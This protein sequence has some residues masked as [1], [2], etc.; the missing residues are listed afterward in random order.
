MIKKNIID[1]A[2]TLGTIVPESNVG[3][4][5]K[6]LVTSYDVDPDGFETIKALDE[7]FDDLRECEEEDM[8]DGYSISSHDYSMLLLHLIVNDGR[9]FSSFHDDDEDDDSEEKSAIHLPSG[10]T[11]ARPHPL[12]KNVEKPRLFFD[13]QRF[14]T[15]LTCWS[16]NGVEWAFERSSKLIEESEP[17]AV[18]LHGDPVRFAEKAQYLSELVTKR[19]GGIRVLAATYGDSYGPNPKRVWAKCAKALEKFVDTLMSNC[20]RSWKSKIRGSRVVD[21]D[22]LA[23]ECVQAMRDAAPT[24][25][26]SMTSYGW[27][28]SVTRNGKPG[29]FGGHGEFPLKGFCGEGSPMQAD[30]DQVYVGQ[31]PSDPPA[32]FARA[33]EYWE[34]ESRSHAAAV[35]KGRVAASV[36]PWIYVQLHGSLPEAICALG[37]KRRVCLGWSAPTRIDENGRLGFIALCK[38]HK[39]GLTVREFQA[40]AGL[41][42]DGIVGKKTLDAAGVK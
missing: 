35:T 16:G 37:E 34:L 14:V 8:S 29:R 32:T 30:C 6:K 38:I 27:P 19:F 13:G 3:K 11:T 1:T 7:L 17:D 31:K 21:R 10:K 42:V 23:R 2:R 5:C 41:R 28:E 12:G 15:V 25:H 36:E 39:K 22:Q 18:M 24:L 26:L 4:S 40:Q 9:S 20:E 33:E